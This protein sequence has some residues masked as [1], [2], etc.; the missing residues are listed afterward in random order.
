MLRN[1]EM[2]H[3]ATRVFGERDPDTVAQDSATEGPLYWNLDLPPESHPFYPFQNGYFELK[4]LLSIRNSRNNKAWLLDVNDEIRAFYDGLEH[5]LPSYRRVWQIIK[6]LLHMQ[7][8]HG[9]DRI[10]NERIA[11][12]EVNSYKM[13]EPIK[14]I[15]DSQEEIFHCGYGLTATTRRYRGMR[16]SNRL[17]AIMKLCVTNPLQPSFTDSYRQIVI[18]RYMHRRGRKEHIKS[19]LCAMSALLAGN[20]LYI[21][22]K[23]FRDFWD[24]SGIGGSYGDGRNSIKYEDARITF[25]RRQR[26]M[27]K[28]KKDM[29]RMLSM[30]SEVQIHQWANSTLDT[31]VSVRQGNED[32]NR[33]NKSDERTHQVE[34]VIGNTINHGR[35]TG[36]DGF[37]ELARSSPSHDPSSSDPT[38]HLSIKPTPKLDQQ[39]ESAIAN[40]SLSTASDFWVNPLGSAQLSAN[41]S[42]LTSKQTAPYTIAEADGITLSTPKAAVSAVATGKPYQQL[43]GPLGYHIPT[44]TLEDAKIACHSTRASYWQY[45]LYQSPT[46]DKVK[47]HYCKSKAT[48]E[49]IAQLFVEEEILGFDIE[50]KPQAL[51]SEGVKKNAALIQ[52]ASEERIALFHIAR[53]WEDEKNDLV[54]PTLKKIMESSKITKVG[55]SIK[56]DCT[57]LRKFMGIES[58]GLLELSHLY[59]L[60]KFSQENVKMINK[61][62]VSLSQQVEEHLQLPMWKGEVRSSDWSQE[63][64]YEQIYCKYINIKPPSYGVRTETT[65]DAAS[66]SYAGFQLY[67]VLE[68][69][70]KALEPTPPRPSHAELNLPIRLANGQTVATYDEGAETAEEALATLP[71]DPS[72]SLE[73]MARDFL[74]VAVE[75]A[76]TEPKSQ[77]KRTKADNS[78]PISPEVVAANEW[79]LQWRSALPSNYKARATP[80]SLRAYAL[81]HHQKIDV[82]DVAALLRNPPLKEAT[83]ANYVLEAIR[84]ENLPH[85]GRERLKSV[86]DYVDR[87]VQ[88]RYQ[89]L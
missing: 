71:P 60:V 81:W 35:L 66:D 20:R 4:R 11:A 56:A 54:A 77:P 78:S 72:I 39:H 57:R 3:P 59:K 23:S 19:L 51:A 1:H 27:K 40:L 18:A 7:H 47:V 15:S 43:L 55:V 45:T 38:T 16:I 64:D 53:Y 30:Y 14:L 2:V 83:V 79:V 31:I 28:S 86:I 24:R 36:R 80:A 8:L 74:N 41:A 29:T 88:G 85:A 84:I 6:K 46:G 82:P 34:R 69:K 26:H 76:P 65:L 70:R 9:V 17:R 37:P 33:Y 44:K 10:K 12:F 68:G 58:H 32:S 75:D 67:H 89:R 61:K 49:R 52:I 13:F 87:N 21:P 25:A 5:V 62:L 22:M 42:R 48:T 50:W 73:E 63:L